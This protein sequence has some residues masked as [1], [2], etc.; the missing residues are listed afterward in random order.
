M[1]WMRC[2][3][4]LG[5]LTAIV[6]AGPLRGQD[7]TEPAAAL[8]LEQAVA[9]AMERNQQVLIAR[10]QG[11]ALKGKIREV[12]ADALPFLS[13][14]GSALRWRD[15]SFL[16][17]S[18]FD[19]IPF[20]FREG[21]TP[22]GANL[23]D[24]NL[25]V[26]QPLYTSG[27]VG[28][29]LKL[30]SL[31][32][33]GSSVDVARVEQDVR[34][35]VI[36]AFYDLLLAERLLDV[37]RETVAQRQEHLKMARA[38]H[39][40]GV[41]TE[42]DVLRSEVSLANAQPDLIRAEN[43]VRRARAT[44]N[45]LLVRPIDFPTQALGELR[46]REEPDAQLNRI[47]RQALDRRP[48]IQRLRINEL[49]ADAQKKLA[50]AENRL[51]LDFNGQYG[52][53]ARDPANLGNHQFTRWMFTLSVG[54]PL[55]D[56]GRRSGLVRQAVAARRVATL[57]RSEA[58][59]DVRLDVQNA[60]DELERA[61][62]TVEAARLTVHEAERVLTMMQENYRYGAATTLD[63]TDAQ[64]A[65]SVARTNLLR[66]LYDHTLAR[67][68]LRWAMG[69]DPLDRTHDQVTTDD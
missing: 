48:E 33:E 27:K 29:A 61:R 60:V 26:K 15:P 21:L 7:S 50:N 42:V 67:A 44:L 68:Q 36:R 1:R 30:A 6:G 64:T 2:F 22:T 38:R 65:L 58:E 41:A 62:K 53:S 59:S 51:R 52:F 45:N 5:I 43:E 18:S 34:L 63:V 32:S 31:E 47:V 4:S 49:E 57:Q 40:A 8:T 25:S 20:E 17:A 13:L 24:Y 55:F 28:T 69:L 56:G 9:L 19:K 3:I 16:N 39:E 23:F 54:L 66:G 37:S 35:R 10:S 12:R 14:N 46:F 11:D